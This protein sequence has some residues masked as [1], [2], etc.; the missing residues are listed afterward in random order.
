MTARNRE[1][2][3]AVVTGTRAEYGILKPVMEK[4]DARNGLRLS[5]IATG[6]HLSDEFGYT[7]GLIEKDGFNDISE[8]AA[9]RV[10][11]T[12]LA[13][14][15]SLGDCITGMAESLSESKPDMVLVCGDRGEA[16]AGAV[17]AAHLGIPVA[18]L[19][20]GDAASG[21]NVDDS[22]RHSISRFANIHLTAHES[23]SER[24][25]R[26]GE[27]PWRIVRVGSPALDAIAGFDAAGSW[28]VARRMGLKKGEKFALVLQHPTTVGSESAAAEMRAT[29]E[30]V[31]GTGLR[32]VVA[33]PNADAGGR[34]MISVI[35]E[36]VRKKRAI[37]FKSIPHG[38]FLGLMA[39]ASVMVGNSSSGLYEAPS[40]KLPVVNVGERQAGRERAANVIDAP[41][42]KNE[43]GKA[44]EYALHDT[45]F[46]ARLAKCRNPFG[47]GKSSARIVEVL[48]ETAIDGRLLRKRLTY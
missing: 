18:H 31:S 8:V 44:I 21:S 36:F 3:I 6:M 35:E 14:A 33:Y 20:G 40:F 7:R 37:A 28:R 25:R 4:I 47:D 22:I 26:M 29:L 16:F 41:H 11:D 13:M 24:L 32:S 1:R 48:A 30:S 38:D 17:A 5:I 2:K 19:F 39:T 23:H 46:R 42:D 45:G 10:G 12:R 27:E 15:Q 9:L 34:R 43:I